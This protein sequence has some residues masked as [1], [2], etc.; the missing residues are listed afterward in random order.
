MSNGQGN[1]SFSEP[2]GS[3]GGGGGGIVVNGARN[4]LTVDSGGF[5]VLG[6]DAGAAG[7]PGRLLSN[8]EEAMNGFAIEFN[9]MP[10]LESNFFQI[11]PATEAM[12]NYYKGANGQQPA[13]II[14]IQGQVPSANPYGNFWLTLDETFVNP[15]GQIDAVL[16]WGY[17]QSGVGG[18]VVANEAE[19]HWAMESHFQS[20]GGEQFEIHLQSMAKNGNINRHMSVA[21]SKVTGQAEGFWTA[22]N[23]SWFNDNTTTDPYFSIDSNGVG[24]LNGAAAALEVN[25]SNPAF[26]QFEVVTN[27]DGS[28]NINNGTTAGDNVINF[29]NALEVSNANPAFAAVDL[30]LMNSPSVQGVFASG[31]VTGNA[32]P[33]QAQVA[34]SGLLICSIDNTGTGDV[35]YDAMVSTGSGNAVI[36]F[37]NAA[38]TG[39]YT[40]GLDQS[41]SNKFKIA[42]GTAVNSTNLLTITGAGQIGA[43]LNTAPTAFL[44]IGSS[45]GTAGMGPLKLTAGALLAAPEDGLFE[46]DGTNLFFTVGAT[47][48]TVTLI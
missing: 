33:F 3:G 4:G 20:G 25:N 35:Y 28:I 47:R 11:N 39:A 42:Q 27:A 16:Q 12:L 21:V 17:N 43:G 38:N 15:D 24:I 36:L 13:E 22:E 32:F 7:Q 44:H 8:R 19:I 31:T 14:T 48:K 40:A 10:G 34:A 2:P 18:V 5:I 37:H 45:P 41:D 46:Y 30:E 26:G 29:S 6:E 23:W 1:I 9:Q